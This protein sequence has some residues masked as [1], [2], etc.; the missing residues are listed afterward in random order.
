MA[1]LFD[2][3]PNWVKSLHQIET[4]LRGAARNGII[5][6]KDKALEHLAEARRHIMRNAL[7]IALE[8]VSLHCVAPCRDCRSGSREPLAGL[9]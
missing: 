7:G 8:A 4:E 1:D 3:V 6:Q 2:R 5:L 9:S